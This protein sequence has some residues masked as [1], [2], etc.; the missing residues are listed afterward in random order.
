MTITVPGDAETEDVSAPHGFSLVQ[1]DCM[2]PP[3]FSRLCATAY[4]RHLKNLPHAEL[5]L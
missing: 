3:Q 1:Y 5:L 4:T 2:S